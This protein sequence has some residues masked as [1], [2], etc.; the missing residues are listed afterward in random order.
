MRAARTAT[1][2]AS[3]LS[4]SLGAGLGGTAA[5]DPA[6]DK[7]ISALTPTRSALGAHTRG[8]SAEL[9]DEPEAAIAA[10]VRRSPH[11]TPATH[12]PT[13]ELAS[14]DLVVHFPSGSADLTPQTTALLDQLGAALANP[15]LAGFRFR[16]EGHTDT[17]GPDDTNKAL[18]AQ[19]AQAVTAYLEQRFSIA[20]D[21]LEAVGL[22]KEGLAVPTPDQTPEPRNRRVHIVNLG[23]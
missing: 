20:A 16:I 6:V 19:R 9:P 15:K 11:V 18:S 7:I 14:T 1:I 10:P 23:T 2:V 12:R 13:G 21:R 5:A 17:V 8:I 4:V 3:I 22:G